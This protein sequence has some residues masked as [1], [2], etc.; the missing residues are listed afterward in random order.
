MVFK[1]TISRVSIAF[2]ASITIFFMGA[3]KPSQ[4]ELAKNNKFLQLKNDPNAVPLDKA[5]R[6]EGKW[7]A[8]IAYRFQ[9]DVI[10]L[11]T[12]EF[13]LKTSGDNL[14]FGDFEFLKIVKPE[15]KQGGFTNKKTAADSKPVI[16]SPYK[17]T[18]VTDPAAFGEATNSIKLAKGQERLLDF[19]ID[20]SKDPIFKN[21]T[22]SATKGIMWV[23]RDA[24]TL[25]GTSGNDL[26]F[27]AQ[28]DQKPGDASLDQMTGS[29][30][31]ITYAYYPYTN[32]ITLKE[33]ASDLTVAKPTSE[34]E[35]TFSGTDTA[36]AAF[37]GT[38][39]MPDKTMGGS[40][41]EMTSQGVTTEGGLL[42]S[43][44]DNY[45][46]GV[47]FGRGHYEQLIGVKKGK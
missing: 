41:M 40:L 39:F 8:R 11:G 3:C 21:L 10:W 27:I 4:E 37:S 36:G 19:V 1:T 22:A 25:I 18:L 45:V 9:G 34:F 13:S 12:A 17:M 33:G 32:S 24:K 6:L 20:F 7:G 30:E 47:F 28:R 29:W 26:Y 23:A 2:L 35:T 43:P 16:T 44:D 31:A 14:Y 42:L 46:Y 5:D 15:I 38:I